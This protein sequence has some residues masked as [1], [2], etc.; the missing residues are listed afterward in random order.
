MAG[1][2]KSKWF[3]RE[4][5][6]HRGYTQDQLAERANMSKG[7]ISQLEIGTRQYTQELL[8]IFA[9]VLQCDIPDLI[10]R[11]PLEPE[12]FWSINDQLKPAQR[13]Q[14]IEIGKTLVRT[15]TD[16]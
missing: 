1:R 9:E 14:W 15:G 13:V 10:I 11:N 4:W 3:L 5:R 8:E 2:A 16:D 12:G 6:K 7:Y